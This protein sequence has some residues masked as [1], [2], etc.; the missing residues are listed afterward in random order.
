[1]PNFINK[2]RPNFKK[3]KP[4]LIIP[5]L[6]SLLSRMG[7]LSNI[8]EYD[9]RSRANIKPSFGEESNF[10]QDIYK[11]RSGDNQS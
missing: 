9:I 2:K 3:P 8:F 11:V 6:K 5:T 7:T 10:H 1:M 4:I